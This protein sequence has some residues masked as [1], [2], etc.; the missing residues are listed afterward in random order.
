MGR[1]MI[2]AHPGLWC[3]FRGDTAP[4]GRSYQEKHVIKVPEV[5][6]TVGGLEAKQGPGQKVQ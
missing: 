2:H 3:V 6:I 5:L 4:G 1:A